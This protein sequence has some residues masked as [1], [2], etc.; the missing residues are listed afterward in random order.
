GS[1]FEF[2]SPR[3]TRESM[4]IISSVVLI[5]VI[6]IPLASFDF[7]GVLNSA[8]FQEESINED[9]GINYTA[10]I[11]EKEIY[12]EL[13]KIL[14]NESVDEYE[15]YITIETDEAEKIINLEKIEI[16]V[17][18][19]YEGKIPGL[20]ERL[21]TEYGDVLQIGVKKDE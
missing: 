3:R 11:M 16:S 2:I 6:I 18:K 17:D 19:A 10:S 9:T 20:R 13:E 15:I 1:I 8:E 14:I 7:E 4:R 5:S 12:K 21:K